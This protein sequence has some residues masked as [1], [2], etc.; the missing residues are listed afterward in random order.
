MLLYSFIT[1]AEPTPYKIIQSGTKI[2]QASVYYY[3]LNSGGT[4]FTKGEAHIKKLFGQSKFAG[5]GGHKYLNCLTDFTAGN[6]TV[7]TPNGS[8]S[9]K[10]LN[11]CVDC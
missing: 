9:W 7:T 8:I 11:I 3:W 1:L 2:N 5:T 6:V 4:D 10:G